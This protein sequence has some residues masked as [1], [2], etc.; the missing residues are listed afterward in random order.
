MN[1]NRY[2]IDHIEQILNPRCEFHASERLKPAIIEEAKVL[3]R[4]R[5]LWFIP[6][7]A[8]ACVGG[9]LIM[10]ATNIKQN[11][12]I[13][14]EP[15]LAVGTTTESPSTEVFASTVPMTAN[16]SAEEEEEL[17]PTPAAKNSPR[18]KAITSKERINTNDTL[19]ILSETDIPVTNPE[20]LIYSP[21]EIAQIKRQEQEEYLSRLRLMVEIAEHMTAENFKIL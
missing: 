6:W 4:H 20:N 7:L 1:N 16:T 21:E 14:E 17:I 18:K 11:D 15:T 12:E 3:S 19:I 10:I 8:A 2:D 5:N 9:I 13:P